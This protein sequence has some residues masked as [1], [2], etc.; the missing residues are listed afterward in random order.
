M[1]APATIVSRMWSDR[2][3]APLWSLVDQG[4][5]SLGSVLTSIVLARYLSPHLFGVVVLLIASMLFLNT[6]HASLV[7]YPLSVQ[8]ARLD[9]TD[10]Q[11]FLGDSLVSA[12]VL[13]VPLGLGLSVLT[14]VFSPGISIVLATL[15]LLA[16]QLQETTRRALF[17]QLRHRTAIAGDALSYLGQAG[18][19]GA[20]GFAG[21]LTLPRL[22]VA[23]AVTSA[24]GALVQMLQLARISRSSPDSLGAAFDILRSGRP[25]LSSNILGAAIM[26][27]PI[28]M[29]GFLAGTTSSGRFQAMVAI[30]GITN[31]VMYGVANSLLPA[32]ARRSLDRTKSLSSTP[33]LPALFLGVGFA[34]PYAVLLLAWPGRIL[35]VVYGHGSVYT[36]LTMPLRVLAIAYL[37]VVM[38]HIGNAALFGLEQPN[39]VRTVQVTGA[40]V[41]CMAGLP[42]TWIWGLWGTVLVVLAAH[43]IRCIACIRA[44]SRLFRWATPQPGI[45]T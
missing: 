16:W 31:P 10:F 6:I 18:A 39:A 1:S 33:I 30:V 35:A 36:E 3:G 24:L 27:A 7:V 40:V 43:G 41:L 44:L 22:F 13:F 38:V 8:G 2:P 5:V 21:A 11:R 15:A 37:L 42:A 26:Q 4:V 34:V 23:M 12:L 28:W 19:V 32:V 29:L 45:A 25:T 9:G 20:L 17:A 14:A